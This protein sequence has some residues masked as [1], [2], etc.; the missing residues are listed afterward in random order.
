MA[1]KSTI[2]STSLSAAA[3]IWRIFIIAPEQAAKSV[4]TTGCI[5]P[6]ARAVAR[7]WNRHHGCRRRCTWRRLFFIWWAGIYRISGESLRALL[8]DCAGRRQSRGYRRRNDALTGCAAWKQTPAAIERFWR[9]IS[10]KVRSTKN[11][12]APMRDTESKFSGERFSGAVADIALAFLW[13][14]SANFT[15][16]A[17]KP[18]QAGAGWP[19]EGGAESAKSV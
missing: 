15:K 3:R 11:S 2:A 14:R 1:V 12:R 4:F 18:F 17:A 19:N 6:I 5:L 16:D 8:N 9:V 10:C 13:F 7:R